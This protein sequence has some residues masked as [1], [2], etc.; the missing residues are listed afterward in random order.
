MMRHAAA[1]CVLLASP[2]LAQDADP[3]NQ[4]IEGLM[5]CMSG[6]GQVDLTASMLTAAGWTRDDTGED[7][8]VYFNPGTG[9]D[10]QVYMAVDGSFCHVESFSVGS[11]DA[12]ELLAASLG[13]PDGAAFDYSSDDMGCTRLDFDTGVSATITSG[14][15]DP[16]CASETDS[17]V[18]FELTPE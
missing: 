4:L 14:G 2:V 15:N 11:A 13:A 1:L 5:A 17:G 6:G 18:R 12:S 10:S 7:G 9:Q 16:T 8:L 3:H